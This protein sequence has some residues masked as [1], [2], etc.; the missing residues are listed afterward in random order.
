VAGVKP[1]IW[2]T[3]FKSL[4]YIFID[5]QILL[6]NVYSSLMEEI[7]SNKY[8]N[9]IKTDP[10]VSY[11]RDLK[12]QHQISIMRSNQNSHYRHKNDCSNSKELLIRETSSSTY[13]YSMFQHQNVLTERIALRKIFLLSKLILCVFTTQETY[14]S[15]HNLC[16]V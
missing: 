3:C 9:K 2:T 1:V 13:L 15:E 6:C 16:N 10:E 7:Q 14:L 4:W 11:K 5:K 12:W 8:D